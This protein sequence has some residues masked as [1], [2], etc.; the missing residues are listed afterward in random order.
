M[1]PLAQQGELSRM[2]GQKKTFKLTQLFSIIV[3]I[4]FRII[5]LSDDRVH[6]ISLILFLW[7]N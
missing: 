6:V 4:F 1:I 3:V 7:T 5:N 2:K